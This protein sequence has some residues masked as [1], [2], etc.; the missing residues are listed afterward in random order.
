[1]DTGPHARKGFDLALTELTG[2]D[3]HGFLVRAGSA[4][5]RDILNDLDGEP[6][7]EERFEAKEKQANAAAALMSPLRA[8]PSCFAKDFSGDR[9]NNSRTSS[10]S[11]CDNTT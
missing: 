4:A 7:A 2:G 1:M 5:G 9:R 11:S 6:A 10:P 3:E 8:M